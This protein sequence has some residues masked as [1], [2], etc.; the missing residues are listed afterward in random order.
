[1]TQIKTEKK[2][3][4]RYAHAKNLLGYIIVK[5]E[6]TETTTNGD[7]VTTDTHWRNADEN[8]MFNLGLSR[9]DVVQEKA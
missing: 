5:V 1:M 7:I 2:L 8:D 9:V 6:E 4:G 3:T